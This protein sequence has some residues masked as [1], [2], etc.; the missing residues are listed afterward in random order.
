[1]LND[2][3]LLI[4]AIGTGA[5]NAIAGGGTFLT[6][7]ALILVGIPPVSANATS[8]VTVFPGYAT[9]TIGFWQEMRA[10]PKRDLLL[11]FALSIAGGVFGALLLLATSDAIFRTAAP[12]LLIIATTLFATGDLVSKAFKGTVERTARLRALPVLT[13]TTYGGYFNGGFGRWRRGGIRLLRRTGR[14]VGGVPGR[15]CV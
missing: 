13:V 5:L 9:A 15:G 6:L 4:A 11:L 1:M 14:V 2:V 7:P 12:W 10:L 3:I 8:T